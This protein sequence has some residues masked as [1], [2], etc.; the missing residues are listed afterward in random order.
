MKLFWKRENVLKRSLE[1]P[2]VSGSG[3][4]KHWTRRTCWCRRVSVVTQ[5]SRSTRA[6][7]RTAL[8][9]LQCAGHNRN[10][11]TESQK[12]SYVCSSLS[13][14]CPTIN[15]HRTIVLAKQVLFLRGQCPYVCV[16]VC[17]REN[18]K[19]TTEQELSNLVEYVLWCRYK[20]KL[21]LR[22]LPIWQYSSDV[23]AITHDSVFCLV[24]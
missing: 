5:S 9:C 3:D 22:Q 19:K 20:C 12:S 18:W 16:S 7:Y 1:K 2:P 21:S 17:P 15:L 11:R 8:W 10:R 6:H 14:L 13:R 4:V 23:A 24:L